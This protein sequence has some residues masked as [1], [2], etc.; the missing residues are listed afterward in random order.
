MLLQYVRCK[1]ILQKRPGSWNPGM[2]QKGSLYI[3]CCLCLSLLTQKLDAKLNISFSPALGSKEVANPRCFSGKSPLL[4]AYP[5]R[6]NHK[7]QPQEQRLL[8]G[9]GAGCFS[10]CPIALQITACSEVLASTALSRTKMK[11]SSQVGRAAGRT[12]VHSPLHPTSLEIL[13]IG[14]LHWLQDDLPKKSWN[15]SPSWQQA[16]HQTRELSI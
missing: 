11:F 3:V 5:G 13:G 10:F 15:V 12:M 9:H 4:I 6:S 2:W 14:G 16:R 7:I 1:D 8:L